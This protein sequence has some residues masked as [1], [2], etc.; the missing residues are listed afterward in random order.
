MA[1]AFALAPGSSLHIY[2]NMVLR[3][4]D[5]IPCFRNSEA[6]VYL[7]FT[8]I[9]AFPERWHQLLDFLLKSILQGFYLAPR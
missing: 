2:Y 6:A 1:R 8:G 9:A 7:N 5:L 4:N 3:E